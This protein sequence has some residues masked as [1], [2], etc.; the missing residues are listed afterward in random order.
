VDADQQVVDKE[1]SLFPVCGQ[2][3]S[4]QNV[5]S[6]PVAPQQPARPRRIEPVVLYGQTFNFVFGIE[7][8]YTKLYK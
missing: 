6:F 3:P 8:Y 4:I 1:R 5:E 7:D 2:V